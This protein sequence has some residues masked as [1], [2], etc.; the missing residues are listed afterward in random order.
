VTTG[1][2]IQLSVLL[3]MYNSAMIGWLALEGFARQIGTTEFAWEIVIAEEQNGQEFGQHRVDEYIE[4]LGKAGCVRVRYIPLVKW[5]P[6]AKKWSLLARHASRDS[7]VALFHGADNYPHPTYVSEAHQAIAQEGNHWFCYMRVPFYVVHTGEIFLA[8]YYTRKKRALAKSGLGFSCSMPLLRALPPSDKARGVDGHIYSSIRAMKREERFR[9]KELEGDSWKYGFCTHGFGNISQRRYEVLRERYT[10]HPEFLLNW[11]KDV[12]A[13]LMALSGAKP[14]NDERFICVVAGA[15]PN[16]PKLVPVI[17][18]F[19]SRGEPITIL[20]TGQHYDDELAAH[21]ALDLGFPLPD[22]QLRCGRPGVDPLPAMF[23]ELHQVWKGARPSAVFVVGDTDTALAASLVANR[24]GIPLIH[25]EA[26]ARAWVKTREEVN[27]ILCDE[28]A[29]LNLT[30]SEQDAQN[31]SGDPIPVG[32][33][34]VDCLLQH[35]TKRLKP[36]HVLLTLHRDFNVDDRHRLLRILTAIHTLAENH[37]VVFPIHPRTRARIRTFSLSHLLDRVAVLPPQLY[38]EFVG[39]V[40]KAGVVIT[41]SGGV[42]VEAAVIGVPVIGLCKATA[43]PAKHVVHICND[44]DKIPALAQQL[45]GARE[46]PLRMKYLDGKAA[47]RTVDAIQEFLR[48]E[49][50]SD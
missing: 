38:S 22:V 23:V 34:M 20:H 1:Q 10:Q 5:I 14:R 40:R 49:A 46:K 19:R 39:L 48:K 45:F 2:D 27:R 21:F 8:D 6:L 28:L 25:Y 13:R 4:R 30:I 7:K 17:R 43:S 11:P 42:Q 37:P 16:L 18:E 36:R 29:D 26:G 35:K 3:P 50:A 15:R 24:L 33:L 9:R 32:D 12:V 31:L 41:D 47:R 44:P